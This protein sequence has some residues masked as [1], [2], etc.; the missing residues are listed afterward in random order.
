MPSERAAFKSST[1][2]SASYDREARQMTVT[3]HG[4]GTA[5]MHHVAPQR[6]QAFKIADSPGRFL[7]QHWPKG[8]ADVSG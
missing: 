3:F 4:G 8:H 5:T 1:V 6:W 7:A 2:Q